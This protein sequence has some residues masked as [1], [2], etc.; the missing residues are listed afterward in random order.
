MYTK[1][2]FLS[3]SLGTD[4][5]NR[6]QGPTDRNGQQTKTVCQTP[7]PTKSFRLDSG[8]D[9]L[10]FDGDRC[11]CW[12]LSAN[13]HGVATYILIYIMYTCK[14]D[15]L[16]CGAK[17]KANNQDSLSVWLS[18]VMSTINAYMLT[19]AVCIMRGITKIIRAHEIHVCSTTLVCVWAGA[20]GWAHVYHHQQ[21]MRNQT[22]NSNIHIVAYTCS[23]IVGQQ[24]CFRHPR[25][26]PKRCENV[27]GRQR[28]T[29]ARAYEQTLCQIRNSPLEWPYT[30]NARCRRLTQRCATNI[31]YMLREFATQQTCRCS[32]GSTAADD[33]NGGGQRRIEN[34]EKVNSEIFGNVFFLPQKALKK[35]NANFDEKRILNKF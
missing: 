4:T 26:N 7:S 21:R 18:Y 27:K 15:G 16:A 22:T 23:S 32:A 34:E 10:D 28:K 17:N 3:L 13:T 1:W 9:V 20:Y 6:W 5:S 19:L 11:C 29:L 30:C 31:L 25:W 35:F 8:A 33:N 2:M 14:C 24:E 12:V